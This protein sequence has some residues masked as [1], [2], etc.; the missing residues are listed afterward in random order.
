MWYQH[1][2]QGRQLK[3]LVHQITNITSSQLKT[4]QAS[5]TIAAESGRGWHILNV[6][7]V[8]RPVELE[9]LGLRSL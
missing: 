1:V 5:L 8:Q 3:V 2:Y 4:Q 6:Q 9:H 7:G